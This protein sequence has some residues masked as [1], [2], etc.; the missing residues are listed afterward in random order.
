[1]DC[2]S[3]VTKPDLDV[4]KPIAEVMF[5]NAG[6]SSFEKFHHTFYYLLGIGNLV[7]KLRRTASCGFITWFRR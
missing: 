3:I 7:S 1:V 2:D 6:I 4:A 5:R